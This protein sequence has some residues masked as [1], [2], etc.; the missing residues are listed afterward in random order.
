M[1]IYIWQ[2]EQEWKRSYWIKKLL[3][4]SK[5]AFA[6]RTW[7]RQNSCVILWLYLFDLVYAL[8]YENL[9]CKLSQREIQKNCTPGWM[10]NIWQI[11][12]SSYPGKPWFRV[13]PW[14]ATNS[15][16]RICIFSRSDTQFYHIYM[17]KVNCIKYWVLLSQFPYPC[18]VFP[19]SY[20]H[21]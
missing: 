1:C 16:C 11:S 12:S 15:E 4:S 2:L 7:E 10:F 21:S 14:H 19:F 13:T 5:M 6:A 18:L 3:G 8:V 20:H 9:L 17:S